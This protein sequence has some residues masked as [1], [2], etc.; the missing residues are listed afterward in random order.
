M[1]TAEKFKN[2][3]MHDKRAII[4]LLDELNPK[5]MCDVIEFAQN[6]L[7]APIKKEK[8]SEPFEI[9]KLIKQEIKNVGLSKQA[10]KVLFRCG[11]RL[12][13]I[14]EDLKYPDFQHR[15]QRLD[16]VS[17]KADIELKKLFAKADIK[18]TYFSYQSKKDENYNQENEKK[19]EDIGNTKIIK[20]GLSNYVLRY[21]KNFLYIDV[22][23]TPVKELRKYITV[24]MM[25][26]KYKDDKIRIELERLFEKAGIKM[27]EI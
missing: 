6:I 10:L 15:L 26:K 16:K 25:D 17:N 7:C 24:N 27:R 5:Q 11:I 9:D 2:S 14:V 20:A 19:K 22:L 3:Q 13:N 8:E 4:Q 18:M 23:K 12:D 1:E 21:L